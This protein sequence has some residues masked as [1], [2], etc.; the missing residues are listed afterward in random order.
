MPWSGA[1][2]AFTE[3]ILREAYK[4]D[5]AAARRSRP[6]WSQRPASWT[7]EYPQAFRAHIA[8]PALTG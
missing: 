3:D 5:G 1:S 4:D 6:T 2:L 7:E 8:A